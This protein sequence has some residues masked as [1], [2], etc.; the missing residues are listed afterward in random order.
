MK[1]KQ[2]LIMNYVLNLKA[3]ISFERGSWM[4]LLWYEKFFWNAKEVSLHWHDI[5]SSH[6]YND[7]M[8]WG[9]KAKNRLVF[10][11]TWYKIPK[12]I[13]KYD[14]VELWKYCMCVYLGLCIHENEWPI[15]KRKRKDYFWVKNRFFN[16]FLYNHS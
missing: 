13:R 12:C 8:I 10:E 9:E 5:D 2:I 6:F 14:E 16:F 4:I 7:V 3:I 15:Y 1:Q 11:F